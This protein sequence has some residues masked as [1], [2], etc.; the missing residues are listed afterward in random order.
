MWVLLATRKTEYAQRTNA[1]LRSACSLRKCAAC[2]YPLLSQLS[3]T[4]TVKS[5]TWYCL[6]TWLLKL[7]IL[8]SVALNCVQNWFIDPISVIVSLC[9]EHNRQPERIALFGEELRSHCRKT[10]DRP[11]CRKHQPHRYT[12]PAIRTAYLPGASPDGA[13]LNIQ[14]RA[15]MRLEQARVMQKL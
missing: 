5:G 14:T 15:C 8:E 2:L 7:G 4:I 6:I 13:H 1:C 10:R 11:Q 9:C 12:L 3:P